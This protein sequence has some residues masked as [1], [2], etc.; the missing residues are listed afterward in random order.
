M[1]EESS[2]DVPTV[3]IELRGFVTMAS[4]LDLDSG[5]HYVNFGRSH[6]LHPQKEFQKM[7]S[8]IPKRS[9]STI[10]KDR[11]YNYSNM[12][13]IYSEKDLKI[14]DGYDYN[15]DNAEWPEAILDNWRPIAMWY[16][17]SRYDPI[18]N[19]KLASVIQ[20][21]KDKGLKIKKASRW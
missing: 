15:S 10:Y 12:G 13:L 6:N 16:D 5:R 4:N 9:M 8:G 1:D 11:A 19:Q 2:E 3:G 20:I 21:C 7:T 18:D 17:D 14:Y